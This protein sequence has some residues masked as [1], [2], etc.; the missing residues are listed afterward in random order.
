MKVKTKL[1]DRRVQDNEGCGIVKVYYC[2]W[3]QRD[4]VYKDGEKVEV[5]EHFRCS[6]GDKVLLEGEGI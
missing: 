4:M 5:C 1:W 6:E 3:C 2:P